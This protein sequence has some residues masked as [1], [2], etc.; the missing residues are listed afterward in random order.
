M[1]EPIYK[2]FMARFSEA[3]ISYPRKSK[4]VSKPRWARLLKK[5]VVRA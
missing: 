4:T 2:V 3:G 5:Q 1:A